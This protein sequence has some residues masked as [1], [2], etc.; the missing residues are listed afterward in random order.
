LFGYFKTIHSYHVKLRYFDWDGQVHSVKDKTVGQ[1]GDAL[2]MLVFNLTILHLWISQEDAALEL[3]VSKTS[4]LPKGTTQ[5]VVFDVS[6]NIINVSPAL[7]HLSGDV[8]LASFCPE[9]FV[10][11]GVPIGTD[12]F[13]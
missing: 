9:G 8:S 13:V 11:I 10:G 6:H 4:V 1:E 3:N 7:T 5:Q 2:E 12:D